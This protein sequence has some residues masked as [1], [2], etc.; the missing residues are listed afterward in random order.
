MLYVDYSDILNKSTHFCNIQDR[1]L[2][3]SILWLTSFSVKGIKALRQV[4]NAALPDMSKVL[5]NVWNFLNG[6]KDII[7]R[8]RK[9]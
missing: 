9:H 8:E 4:S 3:G 6:I 7:I 2:A 5:Q 1:C